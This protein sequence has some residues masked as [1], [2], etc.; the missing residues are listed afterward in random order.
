[1]KKAQENKNVKRKSKVNLKHQ[2]VA[3]GLTIIVLTIY[4]YILYFL[5]ISWSIWQ[6]WGPL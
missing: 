4:F 1:M 5:N 3:Y 6:F 2:I